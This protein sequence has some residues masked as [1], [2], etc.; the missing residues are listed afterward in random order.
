MTIGFEQTGV[1]VAETAGNVSVC[2]RILQPA[3]ES[4]RIG[5]RPFRVGV[6]TVD[7]QGTNGILFSKLKN[8]FIML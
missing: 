5:N 3:S 8:D 7:G 1:Q 6:T 2:L 4:E